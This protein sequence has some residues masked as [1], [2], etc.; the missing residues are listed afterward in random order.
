M[1]SASLGRDQPGSASGTSGSGISSS[2][3][4]SD[5]LRQ[6]LDAADLVAHAD[7]GTEETTEPAVHSPGV[8][9]ELDM[10]VGCVF[11]VQ[12]ACRGGQHPHGALQ[13]PNKGGSLARL[14]A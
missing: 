9:S 13:L 6:L 4:C 1:R 11:E 7:R 8:T 5:G 2:T 3:V 10:Q 14:A 12:E